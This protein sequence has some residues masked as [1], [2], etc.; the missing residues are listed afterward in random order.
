MATAL[1]EELGDAAVFTITDVADEAAVAAAVDRAVGHFGSLDAMCN[2]AGIVGV[3]GPIADTP[4]DLYDRTMAIL[5][6]GVFVGVK[7]AARAMIAQGTGGAIV[8]V[9]ST[10]GLL[11][12]QGPHVY[13]AAKAG[14]IGLTRSASS[15]LAQ[16]GIRVNAVAP[17][18]IPTPL[19]AAVTTGNV[20]D[21]EVTAK[22]IGS[23]SPLGRAP[24]PFDVA[25]A[26]LFLA[27][28]AGSYVTGQ[29]LAVDAGVTSGTNASLQFYAQTKHFAGDRGTSGPPSRPRS[30]RAPAVW[31]APRS[32]GSRVVGVL[33]GVALQLEGGVLDAE[34]LVEHG[35]Q[36][37]AGLL[38]LVEAEAAL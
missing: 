28:E 10:A 2:N 35:L 17:G 38:R 29:T 30:A 3:V 31:P 37:V 13:S 24:T 20:A 4:M 19:T 32:G 11:G 6:R 26:V 36:L 23:R 18:G 7:H 14:V 33:A 15:E 21:V 12:G 25:E 16:Y 8:N 9:A 1:A 5:L 34:A 22:A 27:S